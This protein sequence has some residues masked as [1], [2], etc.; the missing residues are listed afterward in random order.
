MMLEFVPG[1]FG[2]PKRYEIVDGA[3]HELD[4]SGRPRTALPFA[5]IERA[6]WHQTYAKFFV[7]RTLELSVAGGKEKLSLAQ[8]MP[9]H[10]NAADPDLAAYLRVVSVALSAVADAK[11]DLEV[12]MEHPRPMRW[13]LF[14]V[15]VAAVVGIGVLISVVLDGRHASKLWW[16]TLVLGGAA[17]FAAFMAW[18]G[19]PW[20][21]PDRISPRELARSLMHQVR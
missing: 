5:A 6:R 10:M 17:V 20:R 3:I 15:N 14:L 13:L 9:A 11:P 16:V 8:V 19:R 7:T 21:A 2:S 1:T 18:R 4:E 12:K